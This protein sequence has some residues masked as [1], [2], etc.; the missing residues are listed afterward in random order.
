MFDAS[1]WHSSW[2]HGRKSK[3][4]WREIT[5]NSRST[6]PFLRFIAASREATETPA[7]HWLLSALALLETGRRQLFSPRA[8][9]LLLGSGWPSVSLCRLPRVLDGCWPPVP[10]LKSC[11]SSFPLP[12]PPM[13]R[14]KGPLCL[15]RP[16]RL[17]TELVSYLING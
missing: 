7:A 11:G 15:L 17:H 8:Q 13:Q 9:D 5:S 6:C 3:V 4:L 16:H 14:L 10:T 2:A 1:S 12:C